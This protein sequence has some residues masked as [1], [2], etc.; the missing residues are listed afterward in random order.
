MA[1]T[2]AKAKRKGAEFEVAVMEYLRGN[3][4]D[5]A[6][7]LARA[8]RNDEGDVFVMD[9][10]PTILECKA[11]ARLDLS[12][13]LRELEAERRHYADARG[14]PVEDV[15]GLVVIKRRGVP[16]GKSYLVTTLEHYFAV[17]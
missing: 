10:H 7:R 17:D 5:S 11:E 4:F 15:T 8:G 12:G 16:I 9:G 2:Q 3:G 6:E 13:Y 14:L 1:S